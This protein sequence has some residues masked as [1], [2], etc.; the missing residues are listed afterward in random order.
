MNLATTPI[1]EN[2]TP[3]PPPSRADLLASVLRK[4]HAKAARIKQDTAELEQ[5]LAS[6]LAAA[7]KGAKPNE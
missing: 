3:P 1:M 6:L 4:F 2:E 5:G 7:E